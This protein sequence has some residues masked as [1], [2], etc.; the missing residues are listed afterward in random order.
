MPLG[1]EPSIIADSTVSSSPQSIA[2]AS[3]QVKRAARTY[4][5]R[6]KESQP[7]DPDIQSQAEEPP[8]SRNSVHNTAP[9]GLRG[10]GEVPPT[11]RR[12]R[13][14]SSVSDEHNE[15]EDSAT[16]M[17]HFEF[18]WR[19]KMKAIDD[20]GDDDAR[21][22]AS[23]LAV[24]V[25]QSA[26][27]GQPILLQESSNCST[28]GGMSS[29]P[30]ISHDVF[31]SSSLFDGP[32][33]QGD[34][35]PHSE[36]SLSS[37][38][39][40]SAPH[41]RTRRAR[42]VHEFEPEHETFNNSSP[43]SPLSKSIF[44]PMKSGSSS[45]QPTSEDELSMII[46]KKPNST[47]KQKANAASR[48]SVPSLTFTSESTV[49]KG[50][51]QPVKNKKK[52]FRPPTKKE[53]AELVKERSRFAAETTVSI[54]RAEDRKWTKDF[55][56]AKIFENQ[57]LLQ[58][59]EP[60]KPTTTF[61]TSDPIGSF[62]SPLR[63][64]ELPSSEPESKP[65]SSKV[66][67][68]TPLDNSLRDAHDSGE[69]SDLPEI[70]EVLTKDLKKK[71]LLEM[72]KRALEQQKRTI[73][74]D[75]DDDLEIMDTNPMAALKEEEE[76]RRS[77][78]KRPSEG[79]KRQLHL[80]KVNPAKQTA[81][82][83][84]AISPRRKMHGDISSIISRHAAEDGMD[85]KELNL[86]LAAEAQKR[87]LDTT[88]RKEEE[89]KR[90]GGRIRSNPGAQSDGLAVVLKSVA[91]KA[92]EAS[93]G[94]RKGEE[95]EDDTSDED[96]KP[97]L[98]G[99][100]TPE[101]VNDEEDKDGEN[102]DESPSDEDIVMDD[103]LE[104]QI[105][106][107][108]R[109]QR[110]R[111][112]ASDSES[113]E[114][115]DENTPAP[116]KT[117]LSRSTSRELQTEEEEDKENNTQLMYDRS[118]DK[119]NTAV[120]RHRPMAIASHLG[121][122]SDIFSPPLSP[123][124]VGHSLRTRN[125][126]AEPSDQ[127]SGGARQPFKE[128]TPEDSSLPSLIQPSSLTQ[129]F[130]E[131]LQH[132]S[133]RPSTL[134]H[135]PTLESSLNAAASSSKSFTSIPR[136]LEEESDVF[137]SPSRLATSFSDLF[138]STTQNQ[139]SPTRP[140]KM[141]DD[142]KTLKRTDTLELTQDVSAILQPAFEAKEVLLRKA[143]FIFEKEQALV[144]ETAATRQPLSRMPTLYVNDH[145][146]LTQ[147]RPSGGSPE[148]YVPSPSQIHRN[149][150]Q[151]EPLTSPSVNQSGLR[152]PLRTLS[153]SSPF[154]LD[155]PEVQHRRLRKRG[156]TPP[157]TNVRDSPSPDTPP[158]RL[159]AFD[160]LGKARKTKIHDELRERPDLAEFFENEAAESDEEDAFGFVKLKSNDDDED[161]EDLDRNLEE[162]VDDAEMDKKVL[163]EELIQE[164]YR[165]QL[166]VQDQEDEKFHQGLIHG[167]QRNKRRRGVGIDGSDD[168]SDDDENAKARRA[169]KKARA[170]IENLEAD[171]STRAF[172]ES[173][174]QTLKDDDDEFSYL[175]QELQPGDMLIDKMPVDEDDEDR[176]DE[177]DREELE[178]TVTFDEIRESLRRRREEGVEEVEIDPTD[179]SW[180][181]Q[182]NEEDIPA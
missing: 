116:R 164:K 1:T 137:G 66:L 9:P 103:G 29:L 171:E 6:R 100:A 110:R 173:Y 147:T 163:A 161:G 57:P 150:R 129:T 157:V 174:N 115:N 71:G 177:D 59:Q 95:N 42:I 160:I 130:A 154:P 62:S 33:S 50:D 132:A 15:G 64:L 170:D 27:F 36:F 51:N 17:T 24:D 26:S 158:R 82:G 16:E 128:L 112:V 34:I 127:S 2:D 25:T 102:G 141:V 44:S 133:P 67:R 104:D 8:S 5:R 63:K 106:S 55:F 88:K 148:V 117:L 165:E 79:R 167:E 68:E 108:I 113:D 96:W 139:G 155:S 114:E 11:L 176:D 159:N 107:S 84:S 93:E 90:H 35:P 72:K 143:D 76:H 87:A 126:D 109:G 123:N 91:E 140:N 83:V 105:D 145:G 124:I 168:E 41:A 45:T 52:K 136:P 111:V 37:P 73:S 122:E 70:G 151:L 38:P 54:P 19:K 135:T 85:Q 47:G 65:S 131:K 152:A 179:V 75:E 169:M 153:I 49:E 175:R 4:G 97:K 162:L 121:F 10:E 32:D 31:D 12:H 86:L 81:K 20:Q 48:L 134:N 56:F 77:A 53:K 98:R 156:A 118:E 182:E 69:D 74:E 172:A 43:S 58:V 46:L 14:T 146:F 142:L 178:E 18:S 181:D 166:E 119:E 28:S 89:W 120:V 21:M 99:S 138:E 144:L 7:Q 80:A 149:R 180:I 22:S 39:P 101:H 40:T 60:P 92:L 61:P 30:L 3:M 23:V 13:R 94:T 125:R 78:R